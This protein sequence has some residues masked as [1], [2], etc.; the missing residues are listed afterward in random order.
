MQARYEQQLSI[1]RVHYEEQLAGFKEL[2]QQALARQEEHLTAQLSEQSTTHT[3]HEVAQ[4]VDS[5]KAQLAA[6]EMA[7]AANA[8]QLGKGPDEVTEGETTAN[9]PSGTAE[10]VAEL[11]E[12]QKMTHEMQSEQIESLKWR[13]HRAELLLWGVIGM[14]VCWVLSDSL[15][16]SFNSNVA[17]IPKL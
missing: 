12:L 4:E 17:G 6:V 15:L 16:G 10:E 3:Q 8:Q 1:Q 9:S 2:M 13:A 11:R 5:L 14:V 7:L